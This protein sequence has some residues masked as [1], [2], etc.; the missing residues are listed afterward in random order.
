M[1]KKEI[2]KVTKKKAR[3]ILTPAEVSDCLR[4]TYACLKQV[5][6]NELIIM[7]RLTDIETRLTIMEEDTLDFYAERTYH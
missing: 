6:E 7:E 5:S 2:K 4:D 3:K 1:K